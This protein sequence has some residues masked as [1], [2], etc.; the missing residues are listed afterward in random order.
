MLS[1][2][3]ASTNANTV[4]KTVFVDAGTNRIAAVFNHDDPSVDADAQAAAY[5]QTGEAATQAPKHGVTKD[6]LLA[7]LELQLRT[8]RDL[9]KTLLERDRKIEQLIAARRRGN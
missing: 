3:P 6:P 2:V 1:V 5:L 8:D 7:A 4:S 9:V